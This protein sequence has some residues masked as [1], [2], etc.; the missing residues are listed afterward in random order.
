M[1]KVEKADC[2]SIDDAAAYLRVTRVELYSYVNILGMERRRFPKD[3]KTYI[4]K[5]DLET[6]K[7]RLEGLT[8]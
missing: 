1:P 3:R 8:K 6:I 7:R 5:A 4:A 2:L